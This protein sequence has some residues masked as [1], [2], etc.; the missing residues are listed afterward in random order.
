MCHATLFVRH[1]TRLLLSLFLVYSFLLLVVRPGAPSSILAPSS[2]ARTLAAKMIGPDR[3]ARLEDGAGDV[4]FAVLRP[5]RFR[6][7]WSL[8]NHAS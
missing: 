5:H 1:S 8:S 3:P 4:H 6:T 2:D 7:F